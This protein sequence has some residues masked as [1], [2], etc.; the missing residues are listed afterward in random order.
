M[1]AATYGMN[2]LFALPLYN[3]GMGVASVLFYR[4]AIA[5]LILAAIMKIQRI[6]FGVRR[7]DL[8]AL[9]GLGLLFSF[10]S[11][12]LFTSYNYMDAGVASTIL[13]V[14]PVMVAVIMSLFFNEKVSLLTAACIVMSL[15]G[16]GLLS[17]GGGR[18]ASVA[19]IVFVLLSALSYAVY[20][21][22]L[23]RCSAREFPAVK[24]TFYALLFGLPVFVVRTD[25]LTG[26]EGVASGWLWIDI[27]LLATLPTVVS[28]I[29][30]AVSI[31]SIGS[32]AAAILGAME[33][34]TALF[35]GVMI[36]GEKLTPRIALGVVLIL[37]AV[38]LVVAGKP[39]LA[40]AR[41]RLRKL[42]H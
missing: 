27:L 16:I 11:L 20:M 28:L 4:Y 36:F 21:V 3:A 14:Y 17:H 29:L 23:N 41:S 40:Q 24:L 6:S 34:V 19:G 12:F 25:F 7:R 26:L 37:V 33:P 9:A 42:V 30:T 22:W 13:F 18:P 31:R 2:P 39:V 1:A 35:F 10:S 5:L 8:P 38:T 32:T 15:A